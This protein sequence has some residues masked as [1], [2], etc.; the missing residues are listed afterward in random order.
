MLVA[1][2]VELSFRRSRPDDD[3]TLI[4]VGESG[5]DQERLP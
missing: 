4:L 1:L 3:A 5:F 2:T